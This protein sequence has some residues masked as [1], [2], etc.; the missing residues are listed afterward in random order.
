MRR[1]LPLL[2][3]LGCHPLSMYVPPELP[4]K[5]SA[6][7][8][9]KVEIFIDERGIP[10]IYGGSLPDVSYGLGFMH[11]R[12]RL[13]QVILL[14]HASQGRLAELFGE[15]LLATDK[16]LRLV[17]WQLDQHVAALAD[18]DRRVLDAYARGLS[19][20]AKHAGQSAE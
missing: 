12:D 18:N 17:S 6:A 8:Q 4:P 14:Q 10:H 11:A 9:A 2:L 5:L 3:L 16:R 19:D 1:A 20:G 7:V 15:D 13:F